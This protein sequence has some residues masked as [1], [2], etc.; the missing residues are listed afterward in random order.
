MKQNILAAFVLLFAIA[1]QSIAQDEV[2]IGLRIG[3]KAPEIVEK[4]LDGKELKLSSL[5]GK[6]VLIDF[7]ASWCGPCRREN[8]TVVSAY[9][10]FKNRKF[11]SG[12]GF[13]VYSVSLDKAKE[14]WVK[15]IEADKLTWDYHV[16]DLK[17]W[18]SKYAAVYGVRGIPANF[19]INGEGIIVAKNLRGSV[20]KNTLTQLLK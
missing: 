5:D 10:E 12:N 19:L 18:Y 9:Q 17:G 8:P 7:W 16:S 4:S 2:K 6:M 14:P 15:A 3:N 1:T 13:T 20:L 11:K